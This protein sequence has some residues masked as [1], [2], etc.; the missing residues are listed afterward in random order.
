[1]GSAA[2]RERFLQAA[3][4]GNKSVIRETLAKNPRYS[5]VDVVR[6]FHLAAEGNHVSVMR[7]IKSSTPIEMNALD[8]RGR[9]AMHLTTCAEAIEWLVDEG[10]YLTKEDREG[11]TP[12][13]WAA[14]HASVETTEALLKHVLD[15]DPVDAYR[16]TPLFI[17]SR[18]GAVEIVR[19]LVQGGASPRKTNGEEL[20]YAIHIAASEGHCDIVRFFVEECGVEADVTAARNVN[21]LHLAGT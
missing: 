7:W 21:S 3:R 13:H 14:L 19:L 9:T 16:E 2:S 6:A 8:E 4:D 12:L 1:M 20:F 10:C 18:V 15:P 17:A 11:R 5:P